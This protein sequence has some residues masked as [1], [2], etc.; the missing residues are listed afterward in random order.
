MWQNIILHNVY[1]F[2]ICHT[3]N[4]HIK[5]GVLPTAYDLTSRHLT[6]ISCITFPDE[7]MS[8]MGNPTTPTTWVGNDNKG[9]VYMMRYRVQDAGMLF[10]FQGFFRNSNKTRY[11]IYR[12]VV[13]ANLTFR[14]VA[15]WTVKPAVLKQREDVGVLF[16][17]YL[18]IYSS[19]DPSV[20][21]SIHPSFHPSIYLSIHPSIHRS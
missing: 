10:A 1:H 11:Q 21:I 17:I 16:S 12:P 18:S 8:Y 3:Y 2:R 20:H 4:N 13:E 15:Q 7:N 6:V 5:A 14:L 19:I 9:A